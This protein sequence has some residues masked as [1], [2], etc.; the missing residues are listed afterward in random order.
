[1]IVILVAVLQELR[2]LLRLCSS[3]RRVQ[4]KGMTYFEGRVHGHEVVLA[5]GGVGTTA[6]RTAAETLARDYK[7]TL[8]I[9]AG[10]AGGLK[11]DVAVSDVVLGAEILGVSFTGASASGAG[12][13]ER[14]YALGLPAFSAQPSATHRLHRGKILSANTLVTRASDKRALGSA[15]DALAVEMESAAVAD[16]AARGGIPFMAVRAITDGVGDD[17]P[18]ELDSI[19]ASGRVQWKALVCACIRHPAT[20]GELRRL[21]ARARMAGDSLREFLGATLAQDGFA[22]GISAPRP[23]A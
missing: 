14:S 13:V 23:M 15:F 4:Q 19:L 9:N 18:R 20:V 1:V 10:F 7:P 22:T 3:V 8:F 11:D 17:L 16:V 5:A 21:A 12:K 2:P 6:A